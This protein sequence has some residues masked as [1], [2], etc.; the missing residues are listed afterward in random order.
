MRN[1]ILFLLIVIS[2]KSFPQSGFQN[3][4]SRVNSI[5]DSASKSVVIDSFLTYARTEGIPFIEGD[6]AN[7]IYR[8][9]AAI[10]TVAGDFN[11]WNTTSTPMIRLYKTNFFYYSR[12][13]ES[14]ARLD[15]K[16]VLNGGTWILD[17]ENPNK[18]AGGFGPNSELAMP[19][20]VQPWEIKYQSHINHGSWVPKSIY[21]TNTSSSFQINVYL[22]FNYDTLKSYPTVCFQDGSEYIGL[23]SATNVIDNLVDSGKIEEVIA[24]FVTP[25]NRN[26][27]YAGGKSNQ[28][29]LFFVN[30]LVPYIDSSFSTIKDP[31][32]RLVLGDSFGGN[33]SALISYN[34]PEIFGNCGLHSG[35]FWPNDYEAYNLIVNGPVKNVRFCSVWGTYES[36]FSNMRNFRDNLLSKGYQQKWLELPEGHSWG[37]WRANIDFLLTYFFPKATTDIKE[38]TVIPDQIMLY[39]NYPNPFNSSSRIRFAIPF[40][41]GDERGGFVNLKVFDILGNEITTL[42]NEY[43]SAGSYDVEFSASSALPSGVYFYRLQIG[44]PKSSSGQAYV[45]T[46]KMILLN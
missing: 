32:K 14:N 35:A 26:E 34:H 40:L 6:T 22:P 2:F 12:N 29:R 41:G 28:Y 11:G 7:F 33:I 15:Y 19:E 9:N 31:Q 44:N 45:V 39:Q 25:N 21:S 46:K 30:E 27:E 8:G 10:V 3:F 43:K 36:L 42:V 5:V 23:G 37:L 17:P 24:V 13:F 20:Y 16:F 38:V 1:K 18:V 4:L